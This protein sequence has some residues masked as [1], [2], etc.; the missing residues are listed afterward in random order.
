MGLSPVIVCCYYSI[1]GGGWM[2]QKSRAGL[3]SGA[4]GVA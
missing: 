1:F 4:G 3:V 2:K